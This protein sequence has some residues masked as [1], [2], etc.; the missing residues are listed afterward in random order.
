MT[1]DAT[2]RF[3]NR[4]DDYVRARPGYPDSVVDTLERE[5]GL[6][7]GATLA[8]L[9]AGT[10][11]SAELFLRRGYQVFAIE[12]NPAMRQAAEDRLSPQPGFTSLDGTAEAT[13][14]PDASVDLVLAAQAF[15]WFDR[16]AAS[17]EFTRILRP[18]GVVA[19]LWNSRL[20]DATP[21]L[22]DYEALLLE[23]GTDYQQVNHQQ[24]DAAVVQA[25]FAP[26][27]VGRRSFPNSQRL[28]RNGLRSRL[29]SSSYVPPADDP[30]SVPM[31]ARLDDIFARHADHGAVELQYLT[32]LV[33]G[34]W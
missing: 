13:G 3:S 9:G 5:A 20:T 1:G 27:S 7:P 4:V 28:D 25:F 26:R 30:R 34:R 14:L 21:F 32:E 17:R 2:Q 24:F 10:G 15:H 11:I 19:L 18:R 23:F 22:R 16:P 8:D 31:L 29:L 6:A 33:F 12:P